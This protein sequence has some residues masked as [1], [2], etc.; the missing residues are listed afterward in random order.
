MIFSKEA[1]I[2]AEAI[3]AGVL[4]M[5]AFVSSPNRS[6]AAAG[7]IMISTLTTGFGAALASYGEAVKRCGGVSL[8][9]TKPDI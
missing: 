6:I 5:Y 2:F 8:Y 7:S 9:D 1:E 4:Q 3:P